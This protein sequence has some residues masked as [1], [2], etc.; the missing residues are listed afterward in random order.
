MD[1][2]GKTA[3][4]TGASSGIGAEC[5]RLLADR[6]ATLIIAARREA[7]LEA[8]AHQLRREKRVAV[9]VLTADLA[10][11]EG[12]AQLFERTEG[13]G[14]RIDVLINNAGVGAMGDFLDLPWETT[15]RMLQLN[16]M[17]S[18]ELAYRLGERMRS[19]KQGWILNVASVAAYAPMAG[20]AA[21]AA[22]KAYVLS[23]SFALARELKPHGVVVGCLSPGVTAT[24]F[25]TV[26]RHD[27]PR[28]AAL[29]T[30]GPHE[31]AV[32][33]LDALFEGS[34]NVV[35]GLMNKLTAAF[36]KLLP[37]AASVAAA[38]STTDEVRSRGE[39]P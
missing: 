3:L 27:L 22:S 35:P 14:Q 32:R 28:A 15:Q 33:G 4:V 31:T 8:L 20:Y 18:T 25:H 30:M 26:A 6:G 23:F 17:A 29:V 5:A 12:A 38:S 1:L 7:K 34:P 39:R 10:T 19:R 13:Q 21:Y 11:P 2:T 16:V 37:N 24:E 36:L 9:Q